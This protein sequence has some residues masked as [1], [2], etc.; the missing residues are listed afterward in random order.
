MTQHASCRC[1]TFPGSGHWTSR[2]SPKSGKTKFVSHFYPTNMAH[3]WCLLG[4]VLL[5]SA[6]SGEKIVAMPYPGGTS[7]VF[8]MAKIGVELASRGHEVIFKFEFF[9]FSGHF[10]NLTPVCSCG[11]K[12]RHF[13]CGKPH[14]GFQR[15][16]CPPLKVPFTLK[17]IS[18]DPGFN[19]TDMEALILQC[20]QESPLKY[21]L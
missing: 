20:T 4:V 9:F 6:C 18:Y 1:P 11:V 14:Q 19:K 16:G 8:I 13:L 7:H 17:V 2:K 15:E 5:L 12:S 3:S 10:F 21:F